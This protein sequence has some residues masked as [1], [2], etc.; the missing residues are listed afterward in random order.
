MCE[1][2]HGDL[3]R[4]ILAIQSRK[5]GL[6]GQEVC[7]CVFWHVWMCV[8][9]RAFRGSDGLRAA[10][11]SLLTNTYTLLSHMPWGLSE[12]FQTVKIPHDGLWRCF[13]ALFS[14]KQLSS[15]VLV[16]CM[17]RLILFPS[18]KSTSFA[19]LVWHWYQAILWKWSKLLLKLI[20]LY[21]KDTLKV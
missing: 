12:I 15:T 5:G 11:P 8:Q 3:L 6:N 16:V 19:A 21:N 13:R 18:S 2:Q 9:C 1:K 20:H 14:L 4:E 10:R 17:K 7:V